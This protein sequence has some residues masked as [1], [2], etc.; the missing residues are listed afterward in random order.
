MAWLNGLNNM[1]G[2]LNFL[3]N[4]SVP[5]EPEDDT[6]RNE[7]HYVLNN[8]QETW[9]NE[10][11][12]RIHLN[13]ETSKEIHNKI[14]D[15]C[16]GTSSDESVEAFL[17]SIFA[18]ESS[19]GTR[20]CGKIL[21]SKDVAFK[22]LD[23]ELDPTCIICLECFEKGN[24]KGHRI[25]L[26]KNVSGMC[27][28]GDLEA[29][30]E[31]GFCDD[32]K[33][34][35]GN[36]HIQ[37]DE[38]KF[39]VGFKK[40]FEEGFL[41]G[42]HY[43]LY[44]L[45]RPD[46]S[47]KFNKAVCDCII[48]LLGKSEFLM[49]KYPR[50]SDLIA[51]LLITPSN[52]ALKTSNW[53][54]YGLWHNCTDLES[55]TQTP[56][57]NDQKGTNQFYDPCSCSLLELL[58]RNSIKF[59]GQEKFIGNF[60]ISLFSNYN[61]KKEFAIAYMKL[62]YFLVDRKKPR[63][64]KLMESA[65]QVL[66]SE[67]LAYQAVTSEYFPGFQK[68]CRDIF[69][70]YMED[71]NIDRDKK[72]S[73]C[74]HCQHT[75]KY[76]LMKRMAIR[77][78]IL[79]RQLIK[80]FF[81]CIKPFHLDRIF[82]Y[83]NKSDNLSID[84]IKNDIEFS[85]N[86]QSQWCQFIEEICVNINAMD[87][88]DRKI[89]FQN[90]IIELKDII[91]SHNDIS[92]DMNSKS[93]TCF[94][95]IYERI[96][97]YILTNYLCLGKAKDSGDQ[98]FSEPTMEKITELNA[99]LF[100]NEYIGSGRKISVNSDKDS[101]LE[102]QEK[103]WTIVFKTMIHSIGLSREFTR[104]FW[105]FLGPVSD[106]F[107]YVYYH[108]HVYE[109]DLILL[110]IS[111]LCLPS[112]VCWS[113][114]VNKF[115]KLKAYRILLDKDFE[116]KNSSDKFQTIKKLLNNDESDYQNLMKLMGDH[117]ETLSQIC[118]NEM[119]ISYILN[120]SIEATSDT[121]NDTSFQPKGE[122][123]FKKTYEMFLKNLLVAFGPCTQKKLK[124]KYSKFIPKEFKLDDVV[125]EIVN[126]D[127]ETHSLRLKPSLA[128]KM[129]GKFQY[130]LLWKDA[131]TFSEINE[132]LD[133][134][135]LRDENPELCYVS[136]ATLILTDRQRNHIWNKSG[137]EGLLRSVWQIGTC[138]YSSH[139]M[140]NVYRQIS[141]FGTIKPYKSSIADCVY[142]IKQEMNQKEM[143]NELLYPP[144]DNLNTNYEEINKDL[145][146][147]WF[148]LD[149]ILEG[150]ARKRSGSFGSN[151]HGSKSVG[152][153]DDAEFEIEDSIFNNQAGP[154]KP[155]SETLG[156][157][158][159]KN[160][161][162]DSDNK[163]KKV[164]NNDKNVNLVQETQIQQSD[165]ESLQDPEQLRKNKLKE[166][167][168]KKR[169]KLTKKMNQKKT[170]FMSNQDKKTCEW[171]KECEANERQSNIDCQ[172]CLQNINKD[173]NYFILGKLN[174]CN[175]RDYTKFLTFSE[176]VFDETL[177]HDNDTFN[178]LIS[179]NEALK[180]KVEQIWEPILT[181]CNH[182]VHYNCLYKALGQNKLKIYDES[183]VSCALCKAPINLPIPYFSCDDALNE[184]KLKSNSANNSQNAFLD[185]FKKLADQKYTSSKF[186][187]KKNLTEIQLIELQF[188][189]EVKNMLMEFS[190]RFSS[191]NSEFLDHAK[192][193]ALDNKTQIE[194]D[195]LSSSVCSLRAIVLYT[196]LVGL[197]SIFKDYVKQ[198]S[199]LFSAMTK[200]ILLE[201]Y[202]YEDNDSLK[203]LEE[204]L[205]ETITKTGQLF[206]IKW[207]KLNLE[208]LFNQ[209]TG[210]LQDI[211]Q[212]Q[213]SAEGENTL[214]AFITCDLDE[215]F[216]DF[217]ELLPCLNP[218]TFGY[219]NIMKDIMNLFVS[220]KVL[221]YN[222]RVNNNDWKKIFD[223]DLLINSDEK[224]VD[225][226]L[227]LLRKMIT[228]ELI[229]N[230][231]KLKNNEDWMGS[232]E[233]QM[234]V[235]LM[236]RI[237]ELKLYLEFQGI[238]VNVKMA[239]DKLKEIS[240]LMKHKADSSETTKENKPDSNKM[241][242]EIIEDYAM[243]LETTCFDHDCDNKSKM[244]TEALKKESESNLTN[245]EGME[246]N[247]DSEQAMAEDQIEPPVTEQQPLEDQM[248][249][250]NPEPDTA[251]SEPSQ[252]L[253]QPPAQ[254]TNVIRL[255]NYQG[256]NEEQRQAQIRQ[257]SVT[258]MD[259]FDRII[260]VSGEQDNE[261]K[262]IKRRLSE[263]LKTS[264]VDKNELQNKRLGFTLKK[265]FDHRLI[266]N[267]IDVDYEFFKFKRELQ[268]SFINIERLFFD[269]YQNKLYRKCDNCCDFP[270]KT[271][272]AICLLCNYLVCQ[273]KCSNYK[274]SP[275]KRNFSI[276]KKIRYWKLDQ[277]RDK[278]PCRNHNLC[279]CFQ[280]KCD[281][282]CF[283]KN[284]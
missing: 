271:D 89:G 200:F 104:G 120:H 10:N 222:F 16:F 230:Y 41:M 156:K 95:F 279:Q 178:L 273:N 25:F 208:R 146:N 84:E 191:Y 15:N 239:L 245:D 77:H 265:F 151:S 205:L 149:K 210:E 206:M 284:S 167:A 88:K 216:A 170:D 42:F 220:L 261:F 172:F 212:L 276:I 82:L 233:K 14:I 280:R 5:T 268:L 250:E 124:K 198:Y 139:Y 83:Y 144:E 53:E 256:M 100:K 21:T 242:M 49:K 204:F 91:I 237:D 47:T 60:F 44:Y 226:L 183:E 275:T 258:L 98:V 38:F 56:E 197:N 227:I 179:T 219:L 115:S 270:K 161:R 99:F 202:D 153:N 225:T 187:Q 224:F 71:S 229:T 283:W 175:L 247:I 13:K 6:I 223:N 141:T 211:G 18:G 267:R 67:E 81:S 259:L 118:C 52:Y 235:D 128:N 184:F 74:F 152:Q 154:I 22:C 169:E 228:F 70:F 114:F 45:E 94:I 122:P 171:L 102:D 234:K 249:T 201:L 12:S 26:K 162:K 28:C 11:I 2:N 241:L 58:F 112:H 24:H 194:Y 85:F 109:L 260:P 86:Y 31:N 254:G 277:T 57:K 135:Y 110:Q 274:S 251:P 148:N 90:L 121:L 262:M 248:I 147:V 33:G 173:D 125:E 255:G 32:H 130:G 35:K 19:G 50:L 176:I 87:S 97:A 62:F 199:L 158:S 65:I 163:A 217:V 133:K 266:E 150:W 37:E 117:I 182:S 76:C 174:Y 51:N 166:M 40:K 272:Q 63:I 23:C 127:K 116:S 218:G 3:A 107:K 143:Q 221:Q 238:Q 136:D 246:F 232:V 252:P 111:A 48:N 160:I 244:K 168:K 159:A 157:R 61:F 181:T 119:A 257:D 43:Q 189:K 193:V 132:N 101:A 30:K 69:D 59:D 231:G 269:F 108:L 192:L 207:S 17:S 243:E 186:Y 54:K 142:K 1:F 213:I 263:F 215:L 196:D 78:Q 72:F 177:N 75:I 137:L 73:G 105:G 281:A 140:P 188:S 34:F 126:I 46:N 164:I 129:V 165:I 195:F 253:P 103:F 66:T 55:F 80:T 264:G 106:F 92:D 203:N 9:F 134:K 240:N 180:R 190:S 93:K 96:L 131:Q 39:P 236:S 79:D 7:E 8:D 68:V 123:F 185:F 282:E 4:D 64:S 36:E 214:E 27:D 20:V 278:F 138:K 155:E 29:W 145:Q 209:V 113:L